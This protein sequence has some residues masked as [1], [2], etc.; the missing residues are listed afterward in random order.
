MLGYIKSKQDFLNDK[1][2]NIIDI[3]T[4][5]YPEAGASQIKSWKSL[6]DDLKQS[7]K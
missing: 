7:E 4:K 1:K 5:I 2:E 6:I 3:L